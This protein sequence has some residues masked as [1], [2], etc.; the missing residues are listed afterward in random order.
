MMIDIFRAGMEFTTKKIRNK[1]SLLLKF[2]YPDIPYCKT[3]HEE[4]IH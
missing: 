2:G 3:E 1:T 4:V